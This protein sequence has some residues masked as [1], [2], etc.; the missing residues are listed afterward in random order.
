MNRIKPHMFHYYDV[1]HRQFPWINGSSLNQT[2]TVEPEV[3]VI[4]FGIDGCYCQ[5]AAEIRNKVSKLRG[6]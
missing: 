4:C 3:T 5:R 2:D 6:E 1:Q